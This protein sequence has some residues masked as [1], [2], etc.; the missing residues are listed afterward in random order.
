[1]VTGRVARARLRA[2]ER[3]QRRSAYAARSGFS[4]FASPDVSRRRSVSRLSRLAVNRQHGAAGDPVS[5]DARNKIAAATS[6]TFGQAAGSPLG[7]ARRCAGVSMSRAR[8]H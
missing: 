2:A 6:S 5:G 3:A 7:I 8:P 1:M 4:H